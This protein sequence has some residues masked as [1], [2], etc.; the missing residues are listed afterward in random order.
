MMT[1]AEPVFDPRTFTLRDMAELGA[2]LR[3]IGAT[4]QS[5]EQVADHVVRQLYEQLIDR[6]TGERSCA[7]GRFYKTHRYD[8]LHPDLRRFAQGLLRGDE[9]PRG[10]R[11]LTLLASAGDEPEWNAARDSTAHRAIP[12]ASKEIVAQAPM[13][14]RLLQQLGV[15]LEVLLDHVANSGA[16]LVDEQ[17]ATFNVFYVPDARGSPHIP[18]QAD[19]VMK[20]GIRSV[21]GFGGTLPLGDI[22]CVILFSKVRIPRQTAE[23]FRTL[24][25]NVKVAVLPFEDRVFAG[26][27]TDALRPT[28]TDRKGAETL[29]LLERI[30]TLEQLLEVCETRVIDQS[31][32]LY[33]ERERLRAQ[34]EALLDGVLS[35]GPGGEVLFANHRLAEI[36]GVA[37]STLEGDKDRV[38]RAL[39]ARTLEPSGFLARV[40]E[41]E[42]GETSREEIALRDGRTFDQYTAPIRS[43]TGDDFGRVWHFRDITEVKQMGRMKDEFISSVS[44]ELRT[45][46]TSIRA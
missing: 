35:I 6:D 23:L 2:A 21:L 24:A 7:L 15:Q 34:G 20:F 18:A 16:L 25:L 32:R 45:P 46:L 14:S 39:A 17:P 42:T 9:A 10:F 43:R 37:P 4:A 29:G 40:A 38:F 8:D 33:A 5:M 28:M 11:C 30:G 3:K 22:F 26:R 1:P 13:I 36:W 31:E 19:F 44:H 12:L 27:V 41:F